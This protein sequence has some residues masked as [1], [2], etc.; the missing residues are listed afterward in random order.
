MRQHAVL[1]KAFKDLNKHGLQ[2]TR[3]DRIE[4]RAD[5]IVTGHLLHVEQGISVIL[6]FGVLQPALVLQK[7]RRLGEKDPEGT[8]GGIGDSIAGV[9]T[10]FAIELVASF[11][12][13]SNFLRYTEKS[14]AC[15]T[16]APL[17]RTGNTCCNSVPSRPTPVP[18][19][20]AFF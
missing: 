4:E 1:L 19:Y 11:V 15:A 7:R 20:R 5:V 18:K 13:A 6:S 16:K 14:H 8:Q 17:E 2:R 10:R 9:G 3:R 12:N